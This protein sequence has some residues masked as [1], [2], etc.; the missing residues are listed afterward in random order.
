[1]GNC[2]WQNRI[3]YESK[4]HSMWQNQNETVDVPIETCENEENIE[5]EDEPQNEM[6]LHHQRQKKSQ[7]KRVSWNK[8]LIDV[9][10]ISPRVKRKLPQYGPMHMNNSTKLMRRCS[11]STEEVQSSCIPSQNYQ[12]PQAITI[13]SI[14][15]SVSFKE[16]CQK[17]KLKNKDSSLVLSLQ[18]NVYS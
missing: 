1:M 15:P 9:Q 11:I 6:S 13:S 12:V 4:S 8:N 18:S 17:F 14:E 7:K 5:N 3:E 2:M 16:K 10:F